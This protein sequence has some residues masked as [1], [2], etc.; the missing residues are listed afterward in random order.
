MTCWVR[1]ASVAAASVGSASASSNPLVWSDWVPAEHGRERLDG[2]ARDVDERLLGLQRRAGRLGVEPEHHRLRLGGPEPVAHDVG[3]H[4]PGGPELGDLLEKVVVRVEE[5]AEPRP[6]RVHVEPGV[7]RRLDVGD[8]VGQGEP[9]LL[10]RRRPGLA[11]VVARD[12]DRVPARRVLGAPRERVG[13]EPHRRARRVDV[14]PSRG[15]LL[16]DVVLDRPAEPRWVRPLLFRH[17]DVE[18]EQD[19]RRRVDGHR[20][21]HA[22]QRDPVEQLAHVLDGG[23]GHAD[24]ADLALGHRVVGVVADLGRQVERHREPARAGRQQGVV[25]LV[26]RLSRREAGVLAHGPEPLAVHLGVDA[27]GVRELAGRA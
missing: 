13:D 4:P 11:D 15:V 7:E 18:R 24:L 26:R 25:P 5:E 22:L 14:G 19:R 10:G 17:G 2:H 6:E 23:D 20:R 27:A 12:R 8:P 21:G 16:E 3:P 9:E 1:S